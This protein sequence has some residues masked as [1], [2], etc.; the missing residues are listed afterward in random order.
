MPISRGRDPEQGLQKTMDRRRREQVASAHDV[1]DAL[2]GVINHHREMI[3]GRQIPAS[4]D[5]VAPEIWRGQRLRQE[6]ALAI[7]GP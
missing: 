7:F 6:S 2:Q 1:G 3:T 5:D 4:E